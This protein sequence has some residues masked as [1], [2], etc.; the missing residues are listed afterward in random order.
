MEPIK[1]ICLLLVV[2]LVACEGPEGPMG[3]EGEQGEQGEQGPFGPRGTEGPTGP[4]GARGLRGEQ[5]EPAVVIGVGGPVGSGVDPIVPPFTLEGSSSHLLSV[6]VLLQADIFYTITVVFE[7][8]D[9]LIVDLIDAP[10]G[11]SVGG[12][13]LNESDGT[14]LAWNNFSVPVSGLYRFD[15]FNI[16]GPWSLT[17][18]ERD[19]G[20]GL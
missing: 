7:L 10:T 13:L 14:S 8:E 19:A 4:P 20:D 18:T 12:A 15:I 11:E 2:V 3:P 5:G 16:S 17:I 6:Q 9:Y 1:R